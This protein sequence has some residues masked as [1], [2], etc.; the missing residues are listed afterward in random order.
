MT[1]TKPFPKLTPGR[2][3]RAYSHAIGCLNYD[4]ET[5]APRNSAPARGETMAFLSGIVH[6]RSLPGNRRDLR[7]S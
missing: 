3:L 1:L 4:G 5:V 6:E 2:A 7:R